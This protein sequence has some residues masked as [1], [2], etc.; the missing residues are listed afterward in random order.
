MAESKSIS[1]IY[2]EMA[3]TFAQE[4]GVT[5][6]GGG[7]LAVRLYAVAAQIYALYVQNDWT[8]R[9]CFPQTAEGDYLDYHAQLRGLE[10][11][12]AGKAQGTIRFS[13]TQAADTDLSIPSGTVCMTVGQVRFETTQEGVLP[14]GDLSVDVPA[15]AIEAGTASNAAAETVRIMAVAPVGITS[16]TNPAAFSGGVEEED[17]ETLRARILETYK[18]M[19]NGANAAY[20]ESEALAFDQVVAA[21]ALGRNRGIGTVDVVISTASG[22]PDSTLLQ[23]VLDYLDARREIAVDLQVL[24]PELVTVNVS[25]QVRAAD[26]AVFDTVAGKVQTA[27]SGYFDG[28]LL[29]QGVTLAKLGALIYAVDGVENYQILT[30]A[31]DVAITDSQLP[32]L[33]TLTVEEMS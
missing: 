28:T 29:A 6:N 24:A 21:K 23:Q 20:Y 32:V 8:N 22:T 13:V 25:V 12:A 27:L 17:D 31:A 7:E 15:Q 30:P 10:R 33:G 4:T 14:A 2:Q 26:G 5:P 19:P 9:Q 3:E 1:E 18:R 11:T 16:C